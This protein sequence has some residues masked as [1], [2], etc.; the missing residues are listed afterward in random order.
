MIQDE[1]A[2]TTDAVSDAGSSTERGLVSI[3]IIFLNEERFLREAIESVLAQDYPSW[4]LLLV[5]DGS[6][7]ASPD[8]ARSFARQDA[9]IRC[10]SH[11]GGANRG[12][13]ASRNL[14]LTHSRG[15]YVAFLDAD[16]TYM[17]DRLSRHVAVLDAHPAIAMT[18]SGYIRWFADGSDA[19]EMEHA[20]PFVAAGDL[21]WQ[22]PLGLLIVTRVP[23]LN[24]GTCSL[25]VRR[26]VA[27]EVGG[28]EDSFRGLYED[29]VFASKILARYPV[30]VLQAYLARYR[31]HAGSW[32]R[33]AKAPR[34]AGD[35]A[36]AHSARFA[37]WLLGYLAEHGIDDPLVLEAVRDRQRREAAEP[38]PLG[39]ARRRVGGTAKAVLER[40]LPRDWYIRLLILD[41]ETDGRRARRDY[42]RL[43]RLLS[44]RSR[45]DVRQRSRRT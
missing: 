3:V 22:P 31:H 25:T 13:S 40:V 9:R 1:R 6:T 19:R 45:D 26:S 11:P 44:E 30:Y 41:Y 28:F 34:A 15:E 27:L 32:T 10:L 38:G 43:A 24:M 33:R 8:I 23:Y 29:Q 7:D 39:R 42:E 2:A 4:E 5:D 21:V 18:G 35:D 12:M 16:D 37:D 14:G 36:I 17:P 20:R